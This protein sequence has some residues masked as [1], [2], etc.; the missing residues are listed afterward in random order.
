MEFLSP[1]EIAHADGLSRLIPKYTEPIEETT[2]ASLS[3]E[4]DVKYFFFNI[5]RTS[6]FERGDKIKDKI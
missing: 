6:G 3:S 4:M 2:I 1:K 5:E